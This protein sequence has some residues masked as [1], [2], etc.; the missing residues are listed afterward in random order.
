M[1]KKKEEKEEGKRNTFLSEDTHAE[2]RGA[3]LDVTCVD[4]YFGG[5]G[6]FSPGRV[7]VPAS[8]DAPP[9]K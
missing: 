5:W 3:S 7:L 6:G 1:G 8:R 9:D 4:S 2:L